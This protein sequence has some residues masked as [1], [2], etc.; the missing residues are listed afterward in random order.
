MATAR[1]ILERS[2][3][4]SSKN[5]RAHIT[6]E[7]EGLELVHRCLSLLF[8]AGSRIN[9]EA[10]GHR[11]VVSPDAGLGGYPKPA[12]PFHKAAELIY[13]IEDEA[14]EEV[15]VVP[16]FDLGAEPGKPALFREGN[17]FRP[18]PA[19]K[20][21]APTGPLTFL[22]ARAADHPLGLDIE[23]DPLWPR[24]HDELLVLHIAYQLALKDGREE[25]FEG[26]LAEISSASGRYHDFLEAE[27]TVETRRFA[28]LR[29]YNSKRLQVLGGGA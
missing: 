15:V 20:G 29:R 8:A 22:Y 10:F 14:G 16:F 13:W 21:L 9:P 17:V 27:V 2:L 11:A 12:P 6:W 3:A 26:L 7:V 24:Q 4:K 19:T 1:E 25:E 5:Q 23:I 18:V 28:N